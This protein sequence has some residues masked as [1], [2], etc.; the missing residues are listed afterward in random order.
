MIKTK[1]TVILAIIVSVSLVTTSQSQTWREL[2]NSAD[3]LA[4]ISEV[5][6]AL[7]KGQAAYDLAVTTYGPKDS[8][9]ATIERRIGVYWYYLG[10][11][12]AAADHIQNCLTIR[13]E[14]YGSNHP[15]VAIA[16]R[17]LATMFEVQSR[18]DEA[19]QMYNK[20]LVILET[21]PGVAPVEIAALLDNIGILYFY[22]G[23]FDE[24]ERSY[25]RAINIKSK[26]DS[27]STDLA[28][29]MNNL[30]ELYRMKGKFYDADQ[31]LRRALKCFE[32]ELGNDHPTVA[33]ALD[34]LALI[35]ID[36]RKLAEAEELSRRALKIRES[37]QGSDHPELM[38][39][40]DALALA[41]T[42]QQQ[43][44]EAEQLYL[45]SLRIA[46]QTFGHDNEAA[47][48]VMNNLANLYSD[49]ERFD[50][51]LEYHYQSLALKQNIYPDNHPATAYSMLNI[52]NIM[53]V[54]GNIDSAQILF[55][56]SLAMLKVVYGQQHRDIADMLENMCKL[57]RVQG[58]YEEAIGAASEAFEIQRRHFSNNNVALTEKESQAFYRDVRLS[59]ANY[60]SCVIDFG[61]PTEASI[62]EAAE[63][64]L[65]TKGEISDDLFLK[66]KGLFSEADQELT[67]LL[68]TL[69][70]IRGEFAQL[71]VAGPEIDVS[72]YVDYLDSLAVEADRLDSE[73][74]S[75]S[76]RYRLEQGA[77]RVTAKALSEKLPEQ[78]TLIEFYHFYYQQLSPLKMV[79]RYVALILKNGSPPLVLD[80]GEAEPVDSLVLELRLHFNQIA[81]YRPVPTQADFDEYSLLAKSLY[82]L[83]WHPVS[84][85]LADEELILIAPDGSL[86]SISF[87][88]LIDEEDN[89]LISSK[90]IHYLSSGRDL[91]RYQGEF[92]SS[93]GLLALGDPDYNASTE[94]RLASQ[95]SST[96]RD[97]VTL[98]TNHFSSVRSSCDQLG[99]L[100]AGPLPWTRAEVMAAAK[101]WSEVSDEPV[102]VLLG[103]AASEERL[104]AELS[105]RRVIHLA[106]HGFYLNSDCYGHDPTAKWG[107]DRMYAGENPL[108]M[109]GLLL[110][111]ANLHGVGSD[112]APAED[113][114]LTA[115][116]VASLNLVGVDRI[117]LSACESGLGEIHQGE[118]VYGLRRAFLMSGARLVVSALWQVPDEMTSD[119]MKELYSDISIPVFQRLRKGQLILIEKAAKENRPA[120]PFGWAGF[121][122][123][124]DW[125]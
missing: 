3:S 98:T 88:A 116:E 59:A 76:V 38:N 66:Q 53:L 68:D 110:A 15:E 113:G 109:S 21:T 100:V 73:L 63:V 12:Q 93:K 69:R 60:L 55:E 96:S 90:T 91:L 58:R 16:M 117:I 11:Y 71:F 105:N 2:L 27:M 121:I 45:R 20:A 107:V 32:S 24:A 85:H 14:I 5:D 87:G 80:L 106:T 43:Y 101:W 49:I 65:S 29:S 41:L 83:I 114:V 79:P 34:V 7:S 77:K 26:I 92:K 36:L 84:E 33:D 108:L 56:K 81:S 46:Q 94:A 39:T 47:G 19:E 89:F 62:Q 70:S 40:L 103:P 8:S 25:N 120:H 35:N 112:K 54:T 13:E 82:Q 1:K 67:P 51:A 125:R 95:Q 31:I 99:D 10:D 78:T 48:R 75:R 123:T 102:N 9:V 57:R 50:K 61:L 4:G 30:G 18:Y 52:G 86:N 72:Q 115:Y 124:G 6:A 97:D 28:L 17:T 37:K 74:A 64:I 44:D 118:G 22:S 119:L 23:R 104:K 122:T 111:G 42:S